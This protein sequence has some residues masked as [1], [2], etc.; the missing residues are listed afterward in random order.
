MANETTTTKTTSVSAA[1]VA[2][3]LSAAAVLTKPD[4]TKA[5][6]DTQSAENAA[7][8]AAVQTATLKTAAA[9]VNP[10]RTTLSK[11]GGAE[12]AFD[13]VSRA[14]D[15]LATATTGSAD[16]TDAWKKLVEIIER[17]PKKAVLDKIRAFFV[18]NKEEKFLNEL[19]AL[20]G[21]TALEPGINIRV[22]L[23]Y[24]IMSSIARGTATR[25]S[26]SL[27]MVRT[28]FKSDDF[29]NWVATSLPRG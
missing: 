29:V 12:R 16:H 21:T 26:L 11:K 15:V 28:V 4:E 17:S 23:L 10:I 13:A 2:K 5:A 19:N 27:E 7:T 9:E 14:L 25:R 18:A 20:Q 3:D 8:Q 22:R 6:A 1:D 24:E